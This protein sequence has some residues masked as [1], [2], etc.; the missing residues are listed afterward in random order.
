MGIVDVITKRCTQTCVYWGSPVN[1][2]QGGKTYDDPVE[3]SCRWEDDQQLF[4]GD[5]GESIVSRAVVYVLQDV[6]KNGMLFLGD[7]DDLTAAEEAD[8]A[9][10]ETAY[11]IKGFQKTPV[12][13]TTTQFVRKIFLVSWGK[14]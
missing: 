11:I 7:L 10:V 5:D 8:P 13:G 12:L 1:D 2:G 3:L 14:R 4:A 9:S 6:D